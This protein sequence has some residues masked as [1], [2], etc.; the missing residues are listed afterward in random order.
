MLQTRI[1]RRR[2]MGGG[3]QRPCTIGLIM[4]TTFGGLCELRRRRLRCWC[5]LRL[6]LSLRSH[7]LL[8]SRSS[9]LQRPSWKL[10]NKISTC[11][12]RILRTLLPPPT[13]QNY[14]LRN[15]PHNTQL[16]DRISQITDCRV[17]IQ[18]QLLF[19]ESVGHP[20]SK[21]LSASG[22]FALLTP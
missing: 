3:L 18:M 6:H 20:I 4:T 14:S 15:R 7:W 8:F 19:S 22:G 1:Y 10:F 11:P 21:M 12:N 2:V 16:S 13:A 17:E 5:D 9:R